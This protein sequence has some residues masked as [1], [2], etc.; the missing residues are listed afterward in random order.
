VSTA[1]YEQTGPAPKPRPRVGG[2]NSTAR[3]SGARTAPIP[4]R[5]NSTSGVAI[6]KQ[7]PKDPAA[8]GSS[9][10]VVVS[11]RRTALFVALGVLAGLLVAGAAF[12]ALR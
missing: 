4:P 6:E 10:V 5:P 3:A 2:P 12:M 9:V 7:V 1:R 8:G 11:H